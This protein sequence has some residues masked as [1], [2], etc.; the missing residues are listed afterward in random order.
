MII[1]SG[2]YAGSGGHLALPARFFTGSPEN[3]RKIQYAMSG[4]QDYTAFMPDVRDLPEN[5]EIKELVKQ[6]KSVDSKASQ[7]ILKLIDDRIASSSV[8]NDI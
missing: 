2:A 1:F 7:K 8:Y 4:I 3:A 5:I 6:Y